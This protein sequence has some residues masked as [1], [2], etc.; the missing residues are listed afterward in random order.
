[1]VAE[2]E[3]YGKVI[4]TGWLIL[5]LAIEYALPQFYS[6]NRIN[7]KNR[8]VKNIFFGVIV[9]FMIPLFAIFVVQKMSKYYFYAPNTSFMMVLIDFLALDFVLYI[10]HIVAH[11]NSV[12]W[13][14]HEIHHLDEKLDATTGLRIHF[15][16]PLVALMFKLPVIYLLS[17]P[18]EIYVLYEIT[19]T[20][21]GIMHHSNIRIPLWLDRILCLI[22]TMPSMHSVHHHAIPRDTNSNYGF[23]F[24]FWDRLFKTRSDSKR[25]DN[26]KF[27]LKYAPEKSLLKLI[28][29][30]FSNKHLR[31]L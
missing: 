25:L 5:I 22:I 24:S 2:I 10:F 26:W 17:M 9:K 23:V 27:G 13:R 3:H 11:K 18:V 16:E 28:Y 20:F 31:N 1:M 21:I 29:Y 14:F 8:I 7:F 4:I 15:G 6:V 19:L 12:V 30:P